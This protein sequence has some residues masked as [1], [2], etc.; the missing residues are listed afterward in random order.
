MAPFTVEAC[1]KCLTLEMPLVFVTAAK[2]LDVQVTKY[3]GIPV[4]LQ[5]FVTSDNS[6]TLGVQVTRQTDIPEM[7]QVFITADKTLGVQVV[8]RQTHIPEM[9]QIFVTQA[10]H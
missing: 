2:A 5:V 8:T 6:K 9:P 3:T 7:S 4:M 10:R 1:S